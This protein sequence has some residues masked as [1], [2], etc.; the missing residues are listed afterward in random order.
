MTGTLM[1]AGFPQVLRSEWIKQFS[2]RSTWRI[3]AATVGINT[4]VCLLLFAS[5]RLTAATPGGPPPDTEFVATLP[6]LVASASGALGQLVFVVLSVLAITNEYSSGMIQSTFWASPRRW[7]VLVAKMVVIAALC[8]AV[9][10]LSEVIG[11]VLGEIMLKDSVV[12]DLDWTTA[13]GIRILLGLILQM[14]LISL[15]AFAIGVLTMSVGGSI[16]IAV[17]ILFVLPLTLTVV[18]RGMSVEEPTG[19]RKVM[20]HLTEFLPTEAGGVLVRQT[21]PEGSILTLGSGLAVMGV[22]VA[23]PLVAAFLVTDRRDF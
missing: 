6:S 18:T 20:A 23:V 9:F 3:L 11:L 12:V 8:A 2:L 17:G 15:L 4:L 10:A 13:T 7:P 21:A 5:Y 22:W 1:K 19:W 16:G 14:V